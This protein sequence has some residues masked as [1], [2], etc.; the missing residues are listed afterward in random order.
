MAMSLTRVLSG[1]WRDVD[2]SKRDLD[3][4]SAE[5]GT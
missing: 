3:K 2:G 4:E 1:E 5:P